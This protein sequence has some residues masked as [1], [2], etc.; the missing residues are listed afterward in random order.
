MKC[1]WKMKATGIWETD[2]GIKV[3]WLL[4]KCPKCKRTVMTAPQN[5]NER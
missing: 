5:T 2:C 4:K 1:K 3:S